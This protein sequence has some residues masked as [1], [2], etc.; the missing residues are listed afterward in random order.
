MTGPASRRQFLRRA[1]LVVTGSAVAGQAAAIEPVKRELSPSMRVSCCAY[2][3]RKYLKGDQPE[4]TLLDFVTT[5][6]EIGFDGVELT[7]YYFP[8]PVT[9]DYLRQLKRH[10][11][12]LGLDVSGTAVGNRFTMPPGPDRDRQVTAV[13]EWLAYG[14]QFGAPCMRVFAG[15]TPKD[16]TDEQARKWVAECLEECVPTAEEHGVV[17]ALENHGGVTSTA[18]GVLEILAQ[19]DSEWVGANLDTGNFRTAD[20]YADIAKVAPYAVTTHVKTEV[21]PAGGQR[22]EADFGRIIEILRGVNYRGYLS[23]EYEAAEDPKTAVP[24]CAR[25]L[26]ELVASA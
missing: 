8:R 20:P 3:Y 22:G 2:S 13:K 7:S 11:F 23:I 16:S 10:C 4:M 5:C 1:A 15:G 26:K 14:A 25:L 12:L 9:P 18:D 21:R 17:L 19:V 6:A 24:R